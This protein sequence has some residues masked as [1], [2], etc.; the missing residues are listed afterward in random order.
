MTDDLILDDIADED[1]EALLEESFSKGVGREGSVV[2]GT[3]IQREG[4][5]FIIDVGLKSEGRLTIREFYDADGQ[6]TIG[7]GDSVDVFVERCEDQNGLAVLSREKAKREEAWVLLEEAFNDGKT[8]DGRIMGKVK[9]GYTVDLGG[10]AAFLPGS[11]VDVR[12]VHDISRLQEETQ[13]FDILK[14]DRRRGNIVVS[15]RTV[16]EK[17]REN[18]RSAL[19]ETLHEGMVLD[20]IVKNITDY[21]AFVDLGGLDG[22]LHITDMSWKRVKHPSAVVNVGDT[23]TVQVIK[24]NSDTQRI[25]LGMK[26]LLIDPWEGI[27]AKYP[28]GAKFSGHVTNITDYGSFVELEPGVEGLAHVSELT[29]TKKN[30]HPS[31]ILEVNQIVEVMVLDVDADRRRISLG[32]KQCQ[33]NPWEAFATSHPVGAMV[34]GE[35]KNITEFGLFVGLEGDIDGLVHLSDITWDTNAGEEVLKDFQKGQEVEAMVLSLD[36]DKE[37]ISLGL[38]QA[39][40]DAWGQWVDANPKGNV[41]MGKVKEVLSS[42]VLVQLA[43]EVD[44]HIRKAEF[45]QDD[46]E[47]TNLTL[48]TEVEC[49]VMQV[50]RQKRKISLSIKAMEV[51]QERDAIKEYASDSSSA[52]TSSLGEALSQALEKANAAE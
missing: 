8:V 46:R 28:A 3:I 2:T 40:P 6:L 34:K 48:E 50:D 45:S 29:W 13:P 43:D 39:Q 21:G 9:G 26:Q 25:S 7:V 22:L 18:A 19:L 41:V 31:K 47:G 14:M 52:A 30:I 20:G 1:F 37:R 44:G 4:D 10:L 42:G 32:I 11:Q 5:E 33:E 38:K 35:I 12:P 16:I 24:F 49:R 17:H 36:P 27:G 51:Q 23:V 15:R